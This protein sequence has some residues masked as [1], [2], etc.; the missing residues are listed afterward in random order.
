MKSA[1][2]CSRSICNQL[3]LNA[4][5]GNS[6]G[7]GYDFAMRTHVAELRQ[8]FCELSSHGIQRFIMPLG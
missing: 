1:T 7:A 3:H 2:L 5:W 4:S 6:Y 8:D